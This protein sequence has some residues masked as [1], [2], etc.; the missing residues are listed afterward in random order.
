MTDW[1]K[2][3]YD[4]QRAFLGL[5]QPT[6]GFVLGRMMRGIRD[7]FAPMFAEFA[8]QVSALGDRR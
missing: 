8:S 7:A 5:W 3:T 2:M 6:P 4:E 1:N